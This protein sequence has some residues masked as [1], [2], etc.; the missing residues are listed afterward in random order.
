MSDKPKTLKVIHAAV[1]SK[2]GWIFF[3]KSH[4]HCFGKA[5]YLKVKM[6][7]KACDQGFL[8][9]N[10]EYVERPEA[11]EIA[12]GN[13]QTKKFLKILFSENLWHPDLGGIHEYDEIEGYIKKEV[14]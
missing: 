7:Q 5:H 1:K 8:L 11:A 13:G 14:L 3:G 12:F 10:G 9:N 6:S 2:D 4:A